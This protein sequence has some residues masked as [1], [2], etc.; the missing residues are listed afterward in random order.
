[1]LVSFVDFESGSDANYDIIF[2]QIDNVNGNNVLITGDV[3]LTGV[4]W[5]KFVVELPVV[6]KVTS[7]SFVYST[8]AYPKTAGVRIYFLNA[9]GNEIQHISS[10]RSGSGIYSFN[11]SVNNVKFIEYSIACVFDQGDDRSWLD[12]CIALYEPEAGLPEPDHSGDHSCLSN[13]K[14]PV[15]RYPINLRNG[16][17]RETMTDLVI[18]SVAQPLTFT[19]TYRQSRHSELDFMGLGW[20]HNHH[21]SLHVISGTP[22]SLALQ[23]EDGGEIFFDETSPGSDEYL[24]RAGALGT[25]VVDDPP[26]NA[27]AKYTL[28]A[29]D[30]SQLVFDDQERLRKRK[31]PNGEE[32]TYDYYTSGY[33]Q[34]L[35]MSVSDGYGRQLQFAYIASSDYDYL[36]LWRVGDHTATD[37]DT[38]TPSGRY[39]ELHYVEQHVD[40]SAVSPDPKAL[41]YEVTDVRNTDD[42]SG[43]RDWTWRY[44]Y[45]GSTAGEIDTNQLDFVVE[46]LSPELEDN[47]PAS[48]ISLK[49]LEYTISGST[50]SQ[51]VQELGKQGSAPYLADITYAFQPIGQN[52]TTETQAGR[53]VT[54]RFLNGVYKG[55]ENALG[56]ASSQYLDGNYRPFGMSDANGNATM[57]TWRN[58]GKRLKKVRD[59]K[60]NA[61]QFDYDPLTDLLS[62][63]TDAQ[64]RK[65]E[66]TYGNLPDDQSPTLI[67][68][69]DTDGTTLL[70]K[71]M[72]FYDD[73]ANYRLEEEHVIDPADGTTVLQKTERSYYLSG[74]GNGLLESVMR[75]DVQ[76]PA[77]NQST[78]YTYD[79]AGRVIKTQQSSLFGTCTF[80]YAVYDAAG[81]VLATV[82]GR[83]NVTPPT[84]VAAAIAM[85]DANDLVEKDNRVTVHEYD[86]LGR[87]FST[88]TNVGMDIEQTALTVYDALNRVVRTIANYI[89]DAGIPNPFTV[90]HSAFDHGADNNENLVTDTTY[91]ERGLVRKQV[92][93]L[94]NVT[95]YGYDDADR[96]VKTVQSASLPNYDNSYADDPDLSDYTPGSN[97]DEDIITTQAYDPAGNLVESV[98]A[99][100]QVTFTVYDELN[101]VVKTIRA[102]KDTATLDLNPGDVGYS[103]ANDPRSGSYTPSTNPDYD[104]IDTTE[105]DAMGRVNRTQRLLENRFGSAQWD[106]TLYGYDSLGRQIKVIRSAA[107]PAYNIAADPDLSGYSPNSAPDKDIITLTVYDQ[108]GRT[109]YSE[110]P[111]GVRTWFAYDGLNRQIKTI[112]NAAGTASDGGSNDPRSSSY[113]PSSD[114]DKDIISR[115]HYDSDGRVQRTEDVIGRWTLYGYDLN[116]RQVRVIRNASDPDYPINNPLDDALSGYSPVSASDEDLITDTVYD[117]QG[118]VQQTIDTRGNVT[119]FAYDKVGRR[120]K[121]VTN[122]VVQGSTD[123]ADWVWSAGNSR[124]EDGANNAIDHGAANDQ[125]LITTSVY[126]VAGRVTQMRDAAGIETRYEYDALGRR[127]TMIANYVDGVFNAAYPDEDLL[128]E[129]EYNRGGQ[130]V[131]MTDVRGTTTGL[132]YDEAGR[133]VEV[134]QALGTALATTAYTCYDKAGRVL[135]T[136]ASYIPKYDENEVLISP[137][138]VSGSQW[139]F[140]PKAHGLLNDENLITEYGYDAA[141]RQISLTNPVGN[142]T[143][144]TYYKDGR[145]KSMTDAEAAITQYRYD[146]IRRRTLVVQGFQAQATDP[147]EWIWNDTVGVKRWEEN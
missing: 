136:I 73:T 134:I 94:G 99:L 48:R 126:D 87:R 65:T 31:W 85:Y 63:F 90:A 2:G 129:T 92:D 34:D 100:G 19:R 78:T 67:E 47:I 80:S 64:G 7:A 75:V 113:S 18:N 133:T 50:L 84:T 117:D 147:D 115:T 146:Q 124:W 40:G 42:S 125:N 76:T 41:L 77:N 97:P 118:R 28:T 62:S 6:S 37:L 45:F 82:C 81:N 121:T 130:M 33:A 104:L 43:T 15:S 30:E 56:N 21:I 29:P 137:D 105:Y 26:A 131:A 74:D 14:A 58:D 140:Q 89:E 32:W 96:L 107:T 109:K 17:K 98:D 86:S 54:H 25:I 23:T 143:Q 83:Q 142:V 20:S 27:N 135:R 122:Y 95:L 5:A 70:S 120:P 110:D 71:Q 9:N 10:S 38:S 145:V 49:H 123:P 138:A 66:Y 79:S 119:T 103:A 127:V 35:L 12:Y 106:T 36:K 141:S 69:F 72:Y 116:N 16:E 8:F 102:A 46:T 39:I 52:V 101:R 132:V 144:T 128:T 22:N 4:E 13:Y 59:A 61:T 1:M 93:V 139:I 91:N 3:P 51:I 53:T 68:V 108:H 112:A 44:R 111:N 55:P 24:G 60:G 114:A 88:T 57:L 11:G